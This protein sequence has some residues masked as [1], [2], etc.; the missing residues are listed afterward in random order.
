MLECWKAPSPKIPP[1][2]PP[3]EHKIRDWINGAALKLAGKAGD[4]ALEVAKSQMTV[5]LTKLVSR[6][7]G[8]S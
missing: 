2:P 6:F 5:E 8:L 1:R 4:A 3:Q 7:L